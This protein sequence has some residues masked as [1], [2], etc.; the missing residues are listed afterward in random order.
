MAEKILT[1]RI[2]TEKFGVCRLNKNEI[3]PE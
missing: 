3:I 1:M 2:L